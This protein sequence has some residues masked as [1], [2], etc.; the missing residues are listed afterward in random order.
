MA[1]DNLSGISSWLSDSL[2]RSVTGDGLVRRALFTDS[3]LAVLSFRRAVILTSIDLGMLR[4]DLGDRLVLADL[5][6]ISD[7]HRR[8]EADL[9][10]ILAE[11][12]P[13]ILGALLDT[14]A[15]VLGRLP[16]VQL[17][18][19]SRMADFARVL[20]A[21]D[22]V[23]G[24]VAMGLYMAQRDRVAGHVLDSD[25]FGMAI[26]SLMEKH[27]FWR[28]TAGDLLGELTPTEHTPRGWPKNGQAVS[29][30]LRRL[31]PALEAHGVTVYIPR[32][33]TRRGRVIELTT[34]GV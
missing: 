18:A 15:A 21:L 24:G 10:R 1:L 4:G 9:D 34:R 14:L 6:P 8:A 17:K 12:R 13:R 19:I 23:T 2:C 22:D 33:R 31:L 11:K 27:P 3:D 29:G 30:R 25:S 7:T 28:G 5:E 26:V 20:V 16:A 32:E